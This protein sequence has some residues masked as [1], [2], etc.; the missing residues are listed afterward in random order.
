MV[1]HKIEEKIK[2]KKKNSQNFIN[3][4]EVIKKY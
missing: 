4:C 1:K 3:L 2:I